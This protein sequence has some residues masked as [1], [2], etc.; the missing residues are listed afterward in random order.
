MPTLVMQNV[1]SF[2][3][4]VGSTT[5]RRNASI[6]FLRQRRHSSC[7]GLSWN[8]EPDDLQLLVRI[9]SYLGMANSVSDFV[10]YR[11]IVFW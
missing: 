11:L 5:A 6:A 1:R 2:E 3:E 8:S 10:W 7:H 4:P 9:C